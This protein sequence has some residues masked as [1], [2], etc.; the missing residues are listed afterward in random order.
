MQPIQ[1]QALRPEQ[2]ALG[3]RAE[4]MAFITAAASM[5]K[6]EDG[7]VLSTK[8]I[9]LC[10][11]IE[12]ILKAY[13]ASR[14][15]HDSLLEFGHD[16]EKT[17]RR[18][19]QLGYRPSDARTEALVEWLTQFHITAD[20]HGRR[21]WIVHPLA[22]EAIAIVKIMMN[23]IAPCLIAPRCASHAASNSATPVRPTLGCELPDP[24]QGLQVSMNPN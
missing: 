14:G 2:K 3:L 24:Q 23:E 10:H 11:A 1:R 13:V 7:P 22:C 5:E 6:P 12:L 21:A 20:R 8:H 4:A 18:A 16:L 19:T 9:L 17:L 15:D